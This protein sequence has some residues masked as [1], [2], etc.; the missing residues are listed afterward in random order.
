M[1][2]QTKKWT[3][4]DGTKIRICDMNGEHLDNTIA[5]LKHTAKALEIKIILE[6][7]ITLDNLIEKILEYRIDPSKI[8]PLYNNL[9]LERKRRTEE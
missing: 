3:T 1:K 5:I 8:N 6:S 7:Y 2:K 9:V 4:K